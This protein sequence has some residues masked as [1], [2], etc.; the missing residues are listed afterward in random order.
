MAEKLDL[1]IEAYD[2][3]PCALR[4][5]EIN[6]L[7]ADANDFGYSGDDDPENAEEYGCGDH[8]FH[9]EL[10]KA[11]SAMKKYDLTLEQFVEVCEKLEDVLRVGVCGWCV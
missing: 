3:L 1:A 11:A 7:D 9:A 8:C 10:S 2:A 5:F 4:T 6:G